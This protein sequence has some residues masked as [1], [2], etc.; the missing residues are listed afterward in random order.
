MHSVVHVNSVMWLGWRNAHLKPLIRRMAIT[1]FPHQIPSQSRIRRHI[2]TRNAASLSQLYPRIL[3]VNASSLTSSLMS[4]APAIVYNKQRIENFG[5]IHLGTVNFIN[6]NCIRLNSLCLSIPHSVR[7]Y[8]LYGD[9]SQSIQVTS[10]CRT[11]ST[12]LTVTRILSTNS[13]NSTNSFT[14]IIKIYHGN[15]L[16]QLCTYTF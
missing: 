3:S 5:S 11:V 10:N 4:A 16:F 13:T 8:S 2:R 9:I 14:Q 6:S 15:F 7:R 12:T 1:T